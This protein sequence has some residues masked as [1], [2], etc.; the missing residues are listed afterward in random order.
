[1]LAEGY[2]YTRSRSRYLLRLVIFALISQPFYFRMLIG[3]APTSVLEYL[4]HWNVMFTLAV[5]LMSLMLL[6]SKIPIVPRLIFVGVC[7]SLAHFGDWSFMIP[8]WA[9]IF[10]VFRDDRRRCAALFTIVSLVLQTTIWL[11]QYDSF[12]AFSYQYGSLLTLIPLHY[13][14]STIQENRRSIFTKAVYYLYYPSHMF[15]LTLIFMRTTS[16]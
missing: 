12:A 6:E 2:R 4:T 11:P 10:H 9:I 15:L 1:M 5:A 13:N 8:V 3:R 7:I 14:N 16:A